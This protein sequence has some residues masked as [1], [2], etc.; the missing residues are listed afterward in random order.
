MHI[1]RV[2]AI[3]AICVFLAAAIIAYPLHHLLLS[4]GFAD[5]PFPKLVTRAL[6]ILALVGLWPLL[7]YLRINDRDGWGFA[8]PRRR[9]LTQVVIGAGIGVVILVVLIA[10]LVGLG[11]RVLESSPTPGWAGW[12]TILIKGL[13]AGLAVGLLEEIWFRGALF[14]A[15]RRFG[16]PFA[17]IV[18][19]AALYALVHFI[20]ADVV[21]AAD[22]VTW[23]TGFSVIAHSFGR[24]TSL[25]I[26]D[27][28]L[29]LFAAGV[30]L[31]LVRLRTGNIALCIGIHTGWVMTIKTTRSLTHVDPY[32][33]WYFLVSSYDGVIGILA[34]A[35]LSVLAIAYYWVGARR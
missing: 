32:S 24:Y 20:R 16:N 33:D 28:G 15:L 3:Y 4:L 22:E 1:T 10:P 30:L 18:V 35:W 19:T 12:S 11:A 5:V 25:G 6:K 31:G 34:A 17:A 26:V 21:V 14:S 29:A 13:A 27:A 9:F 8:L 7:R 2:I 23:S